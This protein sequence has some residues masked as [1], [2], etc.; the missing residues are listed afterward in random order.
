[1]SDMFIFMTY[2]FFLSLFVFSLSCLPLL[3][4]LYPAD[5]SARW[6]ILVSQVLLKVSPVK[7]ESFLTTVLTWST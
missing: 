2:V 4:L 6:F 1:M 7:R 3:L 5:F